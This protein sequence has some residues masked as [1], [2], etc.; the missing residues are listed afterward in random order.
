MEVRDTLSLV[1]LRCH[2]VGLD[3]K[4]RAGVSALHKERG[5]PRNGL[6]AAPS[7]GEFFLKLSLIWPL[8]SG[9]NILYIYWRYIYWS[10]SKYIRDIF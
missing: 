1:E 7:K 6:D 2:A 5:I 4:K 3:A 8:K 10:L 9:G